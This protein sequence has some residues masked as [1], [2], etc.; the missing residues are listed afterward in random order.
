MGAMSKKSPLPLGAMEVEAKAMEEGIQLARDLGLTDID[1]KSDA[2]TMLLA[3]A[4]PDP[5]SSSILKV[6]EGAKLWLN[7]FSSWSVSH[8]RR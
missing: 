6:V 2:Q 5:G 4:G 8:V 1:L 3:F 7:A